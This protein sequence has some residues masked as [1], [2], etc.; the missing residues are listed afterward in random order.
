M[1]EK[2]EKIMKKQWMVYQTK[3]SQNWQSLNTF[4][5]EFNHT[6]NNNDKIETIPPIAVIADRAQTNQF[7]H[8]FNTKYHQEELKIK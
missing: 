8:S 3:W 5:T 4:Q 2:G 6:E 1:N 7:E